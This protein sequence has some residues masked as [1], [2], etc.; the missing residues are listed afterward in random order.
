M[1]PQDLLM[2]ETGRYVI[3]ALSEALRG[4]AMSQMS[5]SKA[6]LGPWRATS[7]HGREQQAD[8]STRLRRRRQGMYRRSGQSQ[9]APILYLPAVL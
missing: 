7:P 1:L 8:P 9:D 5:P 3:S 2:V 4:A 6:E